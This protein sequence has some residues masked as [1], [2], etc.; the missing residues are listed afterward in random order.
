MTVYRLKQIRADGT[1]PL[2][3]PV[4]CIAL[5]ISVILF[6]EFLFCFKINKIKYG[7][8]LSQG[9]VEMAKWRMKAN[10]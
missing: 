4:A 10:L 8:C 6:S 7:T 9:V 1:K 5:Q 2:D 3:V